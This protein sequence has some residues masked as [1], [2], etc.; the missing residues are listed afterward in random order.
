MSFPKSGIIPRMTSMRDSSEFNRWDIWLAKVEFEEGTGFKIRPVLIIDGT[1]CYIL[2]LKITSHGPRK[3]Y[4]GEYEIIDWE[5]AGLLKP[6]T[7][8]VNKRLDLPPESFVKK[9]G[10][11]LATDCFNVSK[12]YYEL[13]LDILD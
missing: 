13:Y 7:I 2:S 4:F 8:R 3:D 1:R 5:R 10:R 6:S 11:L 9:I 12:L